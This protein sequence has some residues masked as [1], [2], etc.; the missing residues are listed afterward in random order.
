MNDI[1]IRVNKLRNLLENQKDSFLIT[2]EKNIFYLTGFN[3]SEGALLLTSTQAYLFV[4][5][6]YYEAAS[7]KAKCCEVLLYSNLQDSL[8]SV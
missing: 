8:I 6:R 5:F 4:D 2:N 1:E 3:K 7:A